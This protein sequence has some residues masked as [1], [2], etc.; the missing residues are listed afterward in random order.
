MKLQG[1]GGN[2]RINLT[3]TTINS[4]GLFVTTTTKTSWQKSTANDTPTNSTSKGW[5]NWISQSPQMPNFTRH[6]QQLTEQSSHSTARTLAHPMFTV[7]HQFLVP[8][9]VTSECRQTHTEL[10]GVAVLLRTSRD[11]TEVRLEPRCLTFDY[12]KWDFKDRGFRTLVQETRSFQ[13]SKLC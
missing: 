13:R 10:H 9:S 12:L 1:D 4:V 7:D 2:A 5:H 3:W 6:R 11:L 8:H